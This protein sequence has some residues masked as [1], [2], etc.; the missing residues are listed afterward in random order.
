MLNIR[1]I[2]PSN[3]QLENLKTLMPQLQ[4]NNTIFAIFRVFSIIWEFFRDF[5]KSRKFWWGWRGQL[6]GEPF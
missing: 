2:H 6:R 5:E 1:R 3:A 4:R